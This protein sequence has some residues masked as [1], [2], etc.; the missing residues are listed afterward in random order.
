MARVR[1]HRRH[2]RTAHG[3]A[4][5]TALGSQRYGVGAGNATMIIDETANMEEA[6]RNTMLSKT[7]DYGSGCSADGNLIIEETIYD[8][9]LSQLEK[10]GGYLASESEKDQACEA[11][12]G[13]PRSTA[14]P[15]RSPR[16]PEARRDR[17]LHLPRRPQVHR[18]AGDGIGKE[19]LFSSEKLTTLLAVYKYRGFD[20]ALRMM[21]G[22]YEVGGKGHSCGIYSFDP[23]HIHRLALVAPVSRIMVRQPQSKANAGA[24]NNGMPMTSSLGCG[25]W[26]GN[27][28]SE[29]IHLKHYMNT[30]WVS[31]PSRKTARPTRSSSAPSSTPNSR[32]DP[33]TGF[34]SGGA[35]PKRRRTTGRRRPRQGAPARARRLLEDLAPIESR[36]DLTGRMRGAVG[37]RR[38]PRR[39]SGPRSAPRDAQTDARTR[40][41]APRRLCRPWTNRPAIPRAQRFPGPIPTDH[42][43][44]MLL[45]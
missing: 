27:A 21:R 38:R 26:G 45:R 13:T 5:P 3:P 30:T 31:A 6:A 41:R 33:L 28:V 17:R 44:R 25:T 7:S 24:F 22:I 20:E 10:E 2:R 36:R 43:S 19:H 16:A 40:P 34:D 9:M 29:N 12:C 39:E 35:A 1:P 32:S 42:G 8:R 15:T 14:P 4:P 18:R 23:D 37:V 11:C